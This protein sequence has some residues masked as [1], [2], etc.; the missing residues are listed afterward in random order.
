MEKILLNVQ[1]TCDYLNIKETK[2]RKLLKEENF[3]I[4][5]GGSIFANKTF[6]DKWIKDRTGN[7]D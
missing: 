6:L 7:V 1:E 2:C 5:I 3:G 4:K